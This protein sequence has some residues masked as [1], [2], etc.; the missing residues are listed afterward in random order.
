MPDSI[1]TINDAAALMR[2]SPRT[3]L[4]YLHRWRDG[5]PGRSLSALRV[6]P[7]WLIREGDAIAFLRANPVRERGRRRKP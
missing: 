3:V 2:V 7:P 1:L 6:G 5:T 4:A